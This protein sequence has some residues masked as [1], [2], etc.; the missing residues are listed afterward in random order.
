MLAGQREWGIPMGVVP[1][2]PAW[3]TQGI[4]TLLMSCFVRVATRIEQCLHVKRM[5]RCTA[6]SN[7]SPIRAWQPQ[8]IG[9]EAWK[10]L[11]IALSALQRTTVQIW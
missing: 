7:H 11:G 9:H 5:Y 1:L 10:C 2:T 3:G 6:W 4:L 8:G